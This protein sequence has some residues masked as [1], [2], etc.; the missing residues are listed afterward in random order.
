MG[1][2]G[3]AVRAAGAEA[4]ASSA[5]AGALPRAALDRASRMVA[6]RIFMAVSLMREKYTYRDKYYGANYSQLL[7]KD[8]VQ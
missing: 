7:L 6:R 5:K 3:R 4:G 8:Q 2:V 1:K